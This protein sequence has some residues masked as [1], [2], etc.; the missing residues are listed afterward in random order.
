MNKVAIG[1]VT[2][3]EDMIAFEP[4]TGDQQAEIAGDERLNQREGAMT[5]GGPHIHPSSGSARPDS[6]L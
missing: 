2:N 5:A 1:R 3:R 4:W 6:R